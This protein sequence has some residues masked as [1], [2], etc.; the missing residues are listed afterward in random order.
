MSQAFDL[1]SIRGSH[2][3]EVPVRSALDVSQI[4]DEISYFKG[5]S[6]VRMLSAYLGD[7]V[8]LRGVTV[9]L[10]RHAYSLATA[11]DLWAALGETSG[12]DVKQLM[13]NW[14]GR[15]GLPVVNVAEES[16]TVIT[17]QSRFLLSGDVKAEEDQTTWPVPL[18]L[19]IY[20][21]AGSGLLLTAKEDR[22]HIGDVDNTFYKFNKDSI[23]FYRTKYP[24][25]RL[26]KFGAQ[27]FRARLS[28]ED[29]IG[30][31]SDTVA[32]AAAGYST[33]SALLALIDGLPDEGNY[34]VWQSIILALSRLRTIFSEDRTRTGLTSFTL[35]LLTPAAEKIGWASSAEG[36]NHFHGLLRALLLENAGMAGHR[37][38]I[39]EALSQFERYTARGDKLAIQPSLRSAV[40]R[41]AINTQGKPAYDAV[42]EIYQT[43]KTYDEVLMALCAL[44]HVPTLDL[45]REFLEF[46]FAGNVKS[47]DNHHAVRYIAANPAV[48]L[49]LWNY[50]KEHY[51]GIRKLLPVDVF[52]TLLRVGLAKYS[53]MKVHD[54][55]KAFFATKDCKGFDRGIGVVLDQIAN[56]S[57]YKE[58]D[59]AAVEEWL[60]AHGYL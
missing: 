6:I 34:F 20:D 54:E 32:L 42:R 11:Q 39:A 43:S 7:E 55:I 18:A 57:A 35:K 25:E 53:S 59:S 22:I 37:P 12:R 46:A 50:V 30:L 19:E 45:A 27:H 4:F 36:E 23:G 58:K 9:Y 21:Q 26:M 13:G 2:P 14:V 51:D 8:F 10:K 60:E 49:E 16:N 17:R 28:P 24:L 52:D 48:N 29:K 33:T 41:I 44:S 40:F 38:T 1:D 47:Q 31:V 15:I 56:A 3:I 5:A